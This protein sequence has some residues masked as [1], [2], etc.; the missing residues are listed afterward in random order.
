MLEIKKKLTVLCV[1]AALCTTS[2]P[3]S[4]LAADAPAA[5]ASAV[6]DKTKAQSFTIDQAIAYAK[7]NSRSMAALTASEA[8]AKAQKEE[9]RKAYKDGRE[10]VFGN[11]YGST[12]DGTFL[13]LSGYVYRSYI[14][15]YAAAQRAVKQKEYTIESEV[16]NAFYTYLNSEKKIEVAKSSLDSA[17]ERVSYAEVKYNNGAISANEL[18]NFRLAET[19]AQNDYNSAL[20]NRDLNMIQLKSVLNYPQENKLTVIGSFTR[21]PMDTTTPEEALKKSETSIA[22]VNAE[23][24][25]A[26][27]EIKRS[28]S[29]THYTS[30]TLGAR[31]AKAEYA[32]AELTYYNTV[33]QQRIEIYKAYNN[34]VSAYEALDY[35]DKSLE[36]TE[37]LVAASKLSFDLGMITSDEYLSAV[38]QLDSLKNSISEAELS[39][40]LAAVQYKL[41][42]DCENTITQEEDPLL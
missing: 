2:A 17:K 11:P 42:Y 16:K 10:Q 20:R 28:K 9:Q 23:E 36:Y 19:K 34:M 14:F 32:Q 8:T 35:C 6:E 41:T 27:A 25:L 39:A 1:A 5:A 15:N 33:E 24:T 22:R 26:L 37:N 3:V 13:M 29:V 7:E 38:Q 21:Q 18:E 4:I 12:S 30:G 40:Y 31:S